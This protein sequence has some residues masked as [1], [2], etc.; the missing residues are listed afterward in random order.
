MT[1]APSHLFPPRTIEPARVQA[2]LAQTESAYRNNAWTAILGGVVLCLIPPL[3]LTLLYLVLTHETIGGWGFEVTFVIMA[4]LGLPGLFL[5]AQRVQRPLPGPATPASEQIRV[6]RDDAD[7]DGDN[8]ETVVL[9]RRAIGWGERANLGPRLILWGI[10]RIRGRSAF[11]TVPSARVAAAVTTLALAGGAVSPAKLLLSGESADDLEPL[12]GVL[13]YHELAD[14]SKRADRVWIT[15]D[16]K[17][18]LGL[19]V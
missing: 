10:G 1:R 16:A 3:L 5:L 8:D 2:A 12:L 13:L 18:K 19:P 6:R 17:R 4:I 15:T 7:N 14:L 9:A 11:G